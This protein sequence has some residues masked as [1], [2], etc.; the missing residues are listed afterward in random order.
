MVRPDFAKWNQ[1]ET[2]IL[3]LSVE[4]TH[5][6]TRERYQAL[7]MV[8]SQKC[9]AT[10]WAQAIGRENETV[11]NWI[12]QYNRSGPT[13]IDYQHSGGVPPFFARMQARRS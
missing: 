6:R 4:A 1:S 10:Q 12:H 7:Y 11:M 9:N 13:S 8:G 5:P 3:R 2:E